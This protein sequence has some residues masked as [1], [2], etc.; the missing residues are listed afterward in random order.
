[1][2]AVGHGGRDFEAFARLA[3]DAFE[4]V[5][6]DW[7]GHGRSG[8]DTKAP[9]A[10]RYGELLSLALSQLKIERPVLLGNSIGG[11]AA[12][13]HAASHPV[14]G[15][16]LCNSA[17]LLDVTADVTRACNFMARF[18]AAGARGAWW[19]KPAFW[20]YYTFLVLP[21]AVARGQ[22]K[23]IIAAGYETAAVLRD[24]WLSFGRPTADLRG[25][26]QA[27][28]APVWVAWATGDRVIP[29]QRCLPTIK[30]MRNARLSKFGGGHA[31]FLESPK[32]FAREFKR[33]AAVLSP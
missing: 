7:P 22:R 33:F 11:G 32:Q 20:A 14:R 21:S 8:P 4:V 29:L 31:A 13:V 25:P 9:S 3:C 17:G 18:F 24:A 12:I 23:R 26:A 5:C 27:L 30:A 2:H 16:V 15:L 19:F 1:L 10:A 28:D 6:I